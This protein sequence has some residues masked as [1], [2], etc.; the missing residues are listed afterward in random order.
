MARAFV[1]FCFTGI[2]SAGIFT[3][4]T[5]LVRAL[6]GFRCA[7]ITSGGSAFVCPARILLVT[8]DRGL[9]IAEIVVTQLEVAE[10]KRSPHGRGLVNKGD[11]RLDDVQD[12]FGCIDGGRGKTEVSQ[13]N[14]L[15][16]GNSQIQL[17][18]QQIDHWPDRFNDVL[19]NSQRFPEKAAKDATRVKRH[20]VQSHLRR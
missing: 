18:C 13:V 10:I 2:W 1:A 20:I 19:D 7:R 8:T 14:E 12:L 3:V 16:P 9:G 5:L 17:S 11:S 6:G 4:K 15:Q